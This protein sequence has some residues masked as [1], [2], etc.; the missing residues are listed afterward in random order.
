M[1]GRS[2]YCVSLSKV[3]DESAACPSVTRASRTLVLKPILRSASRYS[4]KSASSGVEGAPFSR[5][6]GVVLAEDYS[7]TLDGARHAASGY[8]VVV[9]QHAG[10]VDVVGDL[11]ARLHDV[12]D[13]DDTRRI[14]GI[15]YVDFQR[16][17]ARLVL[18][19]GEYVFLVHEEDSVP[20][21]GLL[22][23]AHIFYAYRFYS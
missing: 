7:R 12:H 4:R 17:K 20:E 9:R 21:A 1:L 19:E 14:A 22:A 6:V 2:E 15:C 10:P 13:V 11:A 23:E 18:R 3:S 5:P 8:L 16:F